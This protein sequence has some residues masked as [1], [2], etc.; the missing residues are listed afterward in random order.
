MTI[1]KKIF[2][3][4]ILVS[5]VSPT[6][7]PVNVYCDDWVYLEKVYLEGG[8]EFCTVYYNS[9]SVKIDKQNKIIELWQKN[10]FT[11][12]GNMEMLKSY[13]EGIEKQKYSEFNYALI[14]YVLNYKE[15]KISNKHIKHYSKSGKLINEYNYKT[16]WENVESGSTEERILIKILKDNKIDR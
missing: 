13:E 8:D 10:I 5:L 1:L 16:K 4:V 12:K 15:W 9:S 14:N 3:I 2:L 7:L 6:T 11:D